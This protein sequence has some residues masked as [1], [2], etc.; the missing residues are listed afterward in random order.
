MNPLGNE[1]FDWSEKTLRPARIIRAVAKPPLD[2][3]NRERWAELCNALGYRSPVRGQPWT[4]QLLRLAICELCEPGM[5]TRM[6][7]YMRSEAT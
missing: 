5:A 4:A 3:R 6:I 1:A 7:D 2:E